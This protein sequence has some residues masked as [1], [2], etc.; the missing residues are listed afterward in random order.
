MSKTMHIKW[1]VPKGL[2]HRFRDR[3]SVSFLMVSKC[4]HLGSQRNG[5]IFMKRYGYHRTSIKE[6]HMNQGITDIYANFN[7]GYLV[8]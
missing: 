4:T 8:H 6:R 2:V 1:D 7:L 3:L 5:N